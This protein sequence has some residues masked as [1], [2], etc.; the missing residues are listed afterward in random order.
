LDL[1]VD[2]A[3]D[4]LDFVFDPS[5]FSGICC[6]ISIEDID[7]AVVSVFN[8]DDSV[9]DSVNFIVDSVFV[10]CFGSVNFI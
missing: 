10:C 5:V 4:P 9:A 3:A 2:R 1:S 7:S 6:D 8:F